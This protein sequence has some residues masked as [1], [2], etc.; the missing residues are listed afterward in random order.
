MKKPVKDRKPV[1]TLPEDLPLGKTAKDIDK[2]N[3]IVSDHFIT[4]V[5]VRCPNCFRTFIE[6]RI[7][8]HLRSC[9]AVN[10]HKLPPSMLK[11]TEEAQKVD[12][13]FKIYSPKHE[14]KVYTQKSPES[15][16]TNLRPKSLMCHIW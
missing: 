2:H 7:E 14:V 8:I 10:P 4:N 1:P 9:T 12:V 5:M 6:D 13:D 11:A 15:D 3:N 16:K